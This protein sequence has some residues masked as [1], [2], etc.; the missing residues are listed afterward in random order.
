MADNPNQ[1]LLDMWKRQVEEGTQA[2]LRMMGQA[3]ARRRP[4]PLPRW[5]RRPS[6]GPF[7][8]QGMAAWSKVM[9]Q[10]TAPSPDLMAQWKQ[11]LD[12][13]IAAWSRVLE[14]AMGTDDF[15]QLMGKQLE[16]FLNVSAPIKK[17]AEQQID[18]SLAGLGHSVAQPGHRAGAARGAGRGEDRRARGQAGPRPPA[19][20]RR[21]RAP[22][23]AGMIGI[24]IDAIAV[25]DSAQITRRVTDGDIAAFVDAV[26]DHNPV[27]ADRAYAAS[28]VFKEPIAPG[29]WTAGLISAVI[30]TRLPG[31]G[32]IYLSQDL[33]FL[34]P[35]KAGDSIS[36]RVEVL[37]VNRERNRIRL[38]T[39]CTNQRAEDVLTGEAVVMP[40]REPVRY[41]RPAASDERDG[42]LDA[43]AAGLDGA[44]RR[45]LGH[46]RP[47]RARGRR[48]GRAPAPAARAAL[49]TSRTSRPA[50][51]ARLVGVRTRC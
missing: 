17:A 46:A 23:G 47:L 18:A 43:P 22:D 3:Q 24:T 10:G 15:A 16:G 30:G 4:R 2:W 42:A 29:I 35:V 21:R 34:K 1:Q 26:G 12:Q 41:A 36:A 45:D 38:R 44:G 8:D 6:G 14:Q 49:S 9:T 5:T 31:P 37:E 51:P 19:P 33:K 32:A 11:F 25:G 28:T 39:V 48:A 20:E 40:S 50:R 13:W 7:M 27:H